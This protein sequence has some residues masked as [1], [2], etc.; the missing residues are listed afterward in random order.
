MLSA[1]SAPVPSPRV[2]IT[3][4]SA[5]RIVARSAFFDTVDGLIAEL[6]AGEVP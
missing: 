6:G 2:R 3:Y 4:K 1:A 5:V